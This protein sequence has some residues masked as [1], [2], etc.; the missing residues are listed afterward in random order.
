MTG[1]KQKNT[2]VNYSFD[3]TIS[4]LAGISGGAHEVSIIYLFNAIRAQKKK[5]W[6]PVPCP[7]F[8]N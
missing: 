4:D 3:Y 8:I 1:I 7:D 2:M 6:A 5:R